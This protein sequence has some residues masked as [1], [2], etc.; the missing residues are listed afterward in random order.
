MSLGDRRGCRESPRAHSIPH[1]AG[2]RVNRS[3]Q[4]ALAVAS[5]PHSLRT[6][7]NPG[8]RVE[9]HRV[10]YLPFQFTTPTFHSGGSTCAQDGASCA[11]ERVALLGPTPPMKVVQQNGGIYV[12]DLDH[13]RTVVN[14]TQ[15][16]KGEVR[17]WGQAS[18]G[19]AVDACR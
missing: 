17:C 12:A 16:A 8:H 14:P 11:R 18:I 6:Q 19:W 1:S 10:Q 2:D 9:L 13:P 7:H 4:S 5:G 3:K 15:T